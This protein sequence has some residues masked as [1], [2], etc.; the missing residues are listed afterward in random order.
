MKDYYHI[1]GVPEDVSSEEIKGAFR[2][3]AFEHHPD[4]NPGNERQA[5]ERFKEINE[6]YSVLGDEGKRREYDA[7]KKSPFAG[8]GYGRD[9]RGFQYSQEDIFRNAFSNRAAFE[10]LNRM[11]SQA[12]LRFDEDFLNRVFFGGRGGVRFQFYRTPAGAR[13]SYYR[14]GARPSRPSGEP[15]FS[16]HAASSPVVKKPTFVE[17][18]MGKA[19]RKL[20]KYAVKKSLGIDLDLPLRGDDIEKEIR[21]TPE[22]AVGGCVKQ[23][24]YKQGKEK[25]TIEVTIPSGIASGTRI[26]IAGMGKEGREPGDLYLRIG[27]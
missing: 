9:F 27:V 18:M 6:A 24:R 16:A 1:L 26:R 15:Y 11:F 25:K 3:L 23:V 5:E 10:D 8:A 7:Y 2:R 19:V 20:G 12:G 4:K 22:E 13:R 14:T 17:R 21:I